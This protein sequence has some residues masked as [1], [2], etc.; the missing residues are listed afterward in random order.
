MQFSDFTKLRHLRKTL[1]KYKNKPVFLKIFIYGFLSLLA[2]FLT[3]SVALF[4]W[5]L[6]LVIILP[7]VDDLE[8]YAASQSSQILARDGSVLYN[9]YGEE[10]RTIIDF[11]EIPQSLI[12]ATISIEDDQFYD[13]FGVDVPAII[14]AIWAELTFQN[15]R[16]GSTITQ[17]YIKNTFLS[18]ERKYSRKM[19]EILMA[20]KLEQFKTK[21]E[22]LQ[23]YFNRIPYGHNAYGVQEAA[24]TYFGKDA[25]DLDLAQSIIL[26]ALPQA[27]SYYSPYGD[28]KYTKLDHL[29]TEEEILSRN[30]K[31]HVDLQDNE[32]WSGLIGKETCLDAECKY[33]MYL[34]GRV[35]SILK[36]MTDLGYITSV[37]KEKTLQEIQ[38]IQFETFREEIKAPHFVLWI[39]EQV[40][41]KYGKDI[42]EKGGLRIY[43]TLD[44]GFQEEAER[45]VKEKQEFNL[46]NYNANN[47]AL[48]SLNPKTGEI[49]AMIGSADFFNDE[50]DGKVNM[51]LSYIPTG[52]SFKP[53][54]YANGF[55]NHGLTPAT[56]IYDVKTDF[57]DG[58]Y[59]KNYDGTF[60]G[61]I[62]IRKALGQ[63]RNIPAIKAYFLSGEQAEILPFTQNLGMEYQEPDTEHGSALALG[64][65]GIKFMSFIEAYSVFANQGV[66]MEPYGIS[67]IE[68]ADGEI[69][70]QTTV[71]KGEQILDPQIAYL[72]TDILADPSVRLGA[73]LT[74]DGRPNAAKTG[75]STKR[76]PN[77]SEIRLPKDLLAI[78]YTPSLITGVWVGNA[79]GSALS[80]AA[81]GYNT[82]APIWKSFMDKALEGQAVENFVKPAGITEIQIS[83]ATGLLPSENT[84]PDMIKTEKFASFA[85]PSVIEDPDTFQIVKYDTFSKKLATEFC[86]KEV[87]EEKIVRSYHTLFPEYWRWEV[88]VQDWA[89]SREDFISSETCNL[90]NEL[91]YKQAP[92]LYIVSPEAYSLIS[93]GETLPID[94]EYEVKF[95]VEKVEY[96]VNDILVRTETEEPYDT[97]IF[98]RKDFQPGQEIELKVKIT[99]KLFY[100][101]EAN[102]KLKIIDNEVNETV[103]QGKEDVI[104]E[105]EEELVIGD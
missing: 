36:R 96:F 93:A 39:R 42:L 98:V 17:Q 54:V 57:G 47:A 92:T 94:I 35:D 22:I 65:T 21:D 95:G 31:Q 41:T 56:V 44:L 64:P 89:S 29:F 11:E 88:G 102:I 52:S 33:S 50:I 59:P 55:L 85:L 99:D 5:V 12:D 28:H 34:S 87:V 81:D 91:N 49:L 4:I 73:R 16:G 80:G 71:H 20:L 78:G 27:P 90:H 26:A 66:H 14:R 97:E 1:A 72:I 8:R 74:L 3:I 25:K 84:P 100:T 68:N 53:F 58:K 61:P 46:K 10:K 23:L 79:D 38:A 9:I 19:K 60:M 45:I 7:K 77:N 51:V 13:H 63:S 82:S 37:D 101:G 18:S 105:E 24:R 2:V 104:E 67:R 15:N 6:V 48:L 103:E 30:I 40:E 62:S 83:M 76:D 69:L 86:P 75:T 70:E 32:F 43:T